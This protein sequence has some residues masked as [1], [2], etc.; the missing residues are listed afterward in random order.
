M[1]MRS[2]CSLTSREVQ[3]IP[4]ISVIYTYSKYMH[5]YVAIYMHSTDV[6]VLFIALTDVQ[7]EGI[8]S[9]QMC[10]HHNEETALAFASIQILLALHSEPKGLK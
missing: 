6:A 4:I 1:Q 9:D 10:D 2:N 7:G 5:H 3:F 8:C